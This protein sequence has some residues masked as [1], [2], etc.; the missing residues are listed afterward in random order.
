M[1]KKN[2]ISLEN[3][4]KMFDL[5]TTELLMLSQNIKSHY[6]V[7]YKKKSDGSKREIAAPEEPLKKIQRILLKELPFCIPSQAHGGIAKKSARTNALVHKQSKYLI[8]I[9]IKNAYPTVDDKMVYWFFRI[10]NA[11]P[12]LAK[13][14]TKLTTFRN[15]LP[16]GAPTSL[17]IFNALLGATNLLNIDLSFSNQKVAEHR[18]RYSRYVDDLTFSSSVKIPKS[19]ENIIAKKL[20]EAG[21]KINP[22][23]TRYGSIKKGALR[24]TGIN[25]VDKKPKIPPKKIRRFRGMIGR[26]KMDNSVSEKQVFGIIAYAMGIEKKI[27]NQLLTPLLGYL[28]K[29]QDIDCPPKIK[30]QI[31]KQLQN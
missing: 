16:Q 29:R 14:L 23:K 2:K 21:F 28:K 17:A 19:F 22:E 10:M 15:Q 4:S 31:N 9:D 24:I 30:K 12:Q 26:A 1:K 6:R 8:T 25:I 7:W 20:E 5:D 13:I 18:L 11:S 27:S 3:F